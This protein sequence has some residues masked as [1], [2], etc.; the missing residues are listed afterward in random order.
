MVEEGALGR[1]IGATEERTKVGMTME[2]AYDGH[3][4]L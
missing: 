4:V 2:P 3:A 1:A